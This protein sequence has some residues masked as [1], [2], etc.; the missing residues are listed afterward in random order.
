MGKLK[1]MD[2]VCNFMKTA[3]KSS[4]EYFEFHA[5]EEE[6]WTNDEYINYVHTQLKLHLGDDEIS[7]LSYAMDDID[8]VVLFSY[9]GFDGEIREKSNSRGYH[10]WMLSI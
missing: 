8:I 1:K 4:I 10:F 2:E 5:H 9:N 6:D 7:N 3:T